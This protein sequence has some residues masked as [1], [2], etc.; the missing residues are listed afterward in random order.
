MVSSNPT[1]IEVGEK[2]NAVTSYL[3]LSTI[4]GSDYKTMHKVRS[5]NGGRLRSNLRNILPFEDSSKGIY[6]SGDDRV[7]QTP[8]LAI[9]HSIFKRNHNQL[10]DKLA[11]VNR[12]WD[13]EKI[14]QEARK[15][16][17][18]IYQKIIYEEWLPTFLGKKSCSKFENVTYN[19][20]ID[21][22][23]TNEFSTASLRFFHSFI[24]NKF[25]LVSDDMKVRSM[26]ASDVVNKAKILEYFYDDVMRG[27]LHQ[28]MQLVGYS[29]E[30]L[31]KLFKNQ[32]EVG[33]DLLSMDILRGRDHG[34]PSYYKFLKHFNSSANIKVFNDFSPHITPSG[35]IQLRQ[36]YKSVYDVDL[37]VGAA[38]EII[39]QAESSSESD[40]P[41]IGPTFQCIITEQFKRFKAGD[42]FFYSH[43][44]QFHQGKWTKKF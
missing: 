19:A 2:A 42:F 4:Y 34:V 36:T 15:V 23:T 39:S 38:L 16:N 5:F 8:F 44:K 41:F 29:S 37:I 9:W 35:I 26:N 3:D 7:N 20:D 24:S 13:E 10:A 33:L 27:L 11:G 28:K 31:N 12:H 32:N 43:P 1:Q 22:S 40:L 21:V 17:I 14:F 6:F 30:L 18:A 25:M